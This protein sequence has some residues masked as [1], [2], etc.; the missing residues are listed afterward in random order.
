MAEQL[1]QTSAAQCERIINALRNRSGGMSTLDMKQ[2]L[3]VYD[4]PARVYQLRWEQDYNIV[5]N[6]TYQETQPG[7]LHRIGHYVLL[8]GSWLASNSQEV[9]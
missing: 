2:E 9:A 6:W 5:L 3:D 4:P 1:S 7:Q 8:P